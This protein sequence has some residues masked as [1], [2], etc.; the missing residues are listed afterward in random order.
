MLFC[1]VLGKSISTRSE[2]VTS[3]NENVIKNVSKMFFFG[4]VIGESLGLLKALKRIN[5][6]YTAVNI[7]LKIQQT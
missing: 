3:C 4:I 7:T 2:N 6:H 5:T 1:K